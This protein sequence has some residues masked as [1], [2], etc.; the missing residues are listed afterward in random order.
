LEK[1]AVA[2]L[3]NQFVH[4][5]DLFVNDNKKNEKRTQCDQYAD[6]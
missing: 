4:G 1:F 2:C 6:F 3:G 5:I